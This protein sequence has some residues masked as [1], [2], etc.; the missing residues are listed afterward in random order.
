[1]SRISIGHLVVLIGVLLGLILPSAVLAQGGGTYS[2]T[3]YSLETEE[4][5]PRFAFEAEPG[6]SFQSAVLVKNEG[7]ESIHLLLYAADARTS[8]NGGLDFSNVTDV[9]S[10]VG[11]WITVEQSD[12]TLAAGES[13]IVPFTVHVPDTVQPG[14]HRAGIM[15]ENAT[16]EVNDEQATDPKQV[17]VKYVFRE[18]LNVHI[19]VPGPTQTEFHITNVTQSVENNDTIFNV[20]MGNVGNEDV[21]IASG[22][23]QIFDSNGG[24][25]GEQPIQLSG[26][27]LAGDTISNPARFTGLLPEGHYAVGVSVD[28]GTDVSAQWQSEFDI[29]PATVEEAAAAEIN[30]GFAVAPNP[31]DQSGEAAAAPEAATQVVV[32]PLTSAPVS[33][34]ESIW[35]YVIAGMALI[36]MLGIVITLIIFVTRSRSSSPQNDYRTRGE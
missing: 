14:S 7:S 18:G 28:Y 24:I 29:V 25:I 5:L 10:S 8:V 17:S 3:P 15:T 22:S 31:D 13:Q 33:G 4:N 35:V 19:T 34:T 11:L 27:F 1:M 26:L 21:R 2:L 32:A 9:L 6:Q 30:R 16:P 36:M 20:E 12:L 23:I